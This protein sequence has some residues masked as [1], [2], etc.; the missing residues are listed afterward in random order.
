M[1]FYVQRKLDVPE[2]PGRKTW[3]SIGRVM[4]VSSDDLD[5]IE[6]AYKAEKSPT[7]AL[8]AKFKTFTPEPSMTQFVQALVTCQRNGVA[9]YICNWQWER[10]FKSIENESPL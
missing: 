9:N 10:L 1:L 2:T 3:R 4:K 6:A 8:L 7:E 5:L